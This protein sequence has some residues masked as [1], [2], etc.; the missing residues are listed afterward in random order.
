MCLLWLVFVSSY[1]YILE[2]ATCSTG[3]SSSSSSPPTTLSKA[4]S[5]LPSGILYDH[6]VTVNPYVSVP[7][8]ESVLRGEAALLPPKAGPPLPAKARPV[9]HAAVT[10]MAP[11]APPP[12]ARPGTHEGTVPTQFASSGTSAA[13]A[14]PA[15]AT[16]RGARVKAAPP[17]ATPP[18][19][20]FLLDQSG[21]KFSKIRF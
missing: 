10:P 8:P 4:V 21:L 15:M 11:L 12:K 13:S 19:H 17:E 1:L 7:V 5:A 6:L 16:T 14:L 3:A 9:T 2:T 20:S 18:V